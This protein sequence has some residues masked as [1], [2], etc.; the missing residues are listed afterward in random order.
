MHHL[1]EGGFELL[2]GELIGLGVCAAAAEAEHVEPRGEAAATFFLGWGPGDL[3]I[4]VV[5]G[6]GAAGGVFAGVIVVAAAG[7]VGEGIVCVWGRC[8]VLA[9]HILLNA[10]P[11]DL[12]SRIQGATVARA[13]H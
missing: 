13:H 8:A 12:V 2:V 1:F 4:G 6:E 7:A 11:S 9:R 5:E 3:F 10:E